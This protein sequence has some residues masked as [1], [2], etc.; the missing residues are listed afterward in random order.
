MNTGDKETS[1]YQFD[2]VMTKKRDKKRRAL[3]MLPGCVAVACDNEAVDSHNIT[4]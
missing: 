4:M 2:K 1:L 3:L